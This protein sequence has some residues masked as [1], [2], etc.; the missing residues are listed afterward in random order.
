MAAP[1]DGLG[2]HQHDALAFRQCDAA[3]QALS[4]RR[5]LHVIGIAPEACIPPTRVCRIWPRMPQATQPGH[6]SVVNPRAM[7]SR[8]QLVA[9]ELGIVPRARDCAD[10]DQ[11][12]DAVRVEKTDELLDRPCRVP[13]CED[14]ERRHANTRS[15]TDVPAP[16]EL[17]CR[18]FRSAFRNVVRPFMLK[19]RSDPKHIDGRGRRRRERQRRRRR[20]QSDLGKS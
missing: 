4:E 20:A 7:Q 13:D 16:T 14:S 15:A 1:W 18:G 11:P 2:A 10:I 12:L 17:V 8:R 19:E 3:I 9:T 6:V 5:R